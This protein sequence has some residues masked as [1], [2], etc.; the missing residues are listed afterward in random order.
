VDTVYADFHYEGRENLVMGFQAGFSRLADKSY[1]I[2][3]PPIHEMDF[4]AVAGPDFNLW[5]LFS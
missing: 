1:I 3:K 4:M 5:M 2:S